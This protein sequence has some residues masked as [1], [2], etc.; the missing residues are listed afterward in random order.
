MQ[1]T[2]HACYIL[3]TVLLSYWHQPMLSA[4]HIFLMTIRG[5]IAGAATL[6]LALEPLPLMSA[7]VALIFASFSSSERPLLLEDSVGG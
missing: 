2:I 3:L 5:S 1:H 7:V 4:G 6:A